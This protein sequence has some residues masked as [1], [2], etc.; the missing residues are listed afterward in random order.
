MSFKELYFK[1][2]EPRLGLWFLRT[3]LVKAIN[4]VQ[5]NVDSLEKRLTEI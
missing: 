2:A 4:A 3:E 1:E 5:E